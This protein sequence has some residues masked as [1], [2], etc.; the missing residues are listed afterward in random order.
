MKKSLIFY[1]FLLF[2]CA[3]ST[4]SLTSNNTSSINASSS[5]QTNITTSSNNETSS[6]YTSISSNKSND[7]TSK[8]TSSSNENSYTS[9]SY[10][11]EGG[12]TNPDG[13]KKLDG[14]NNI[15]NP[16]DI[17]EWVNFSFETSMAENFSYIYGNNKVNGDLYA[18]GCEM[19][20]NKNEGA[21]KGFQSPAFTPFKKVEVRLNIKEFHPNSAKKNDKNPVFTIYG[22]DKNSNLVTQEVIEE[23]KVNNQNTKQEVK[24]YLRNELMTYFEVRVTNLPYKGN[25]V[26][27]FGINQVSIKGWNFD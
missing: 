14:P 16:I 27:N 15:N 6:I 21:K 8:S 12:E 20:F 4:S 11:Y 24:F 9:S 18:D 10:K 1:L 26:Y 2:S 25:T 3:S 7:S 5:N 19:Q 22:F 17:S 13:S 23:L